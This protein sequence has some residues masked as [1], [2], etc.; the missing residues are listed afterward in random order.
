[1]KREKFELSFGSFDINLNLY[2]PEAV[3]NLYAYGFGSPRIV[4]SQTI[5]LS[6][7]S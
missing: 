7:V 6:E 1:M 5:K 2:D 4:Y 3:F